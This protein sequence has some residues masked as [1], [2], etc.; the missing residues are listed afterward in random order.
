MG[1]ASI[2]IDY[3]N[4]Y[5]P[6][7]ALVLLVANLLGAYATRLQ[8]C[9]WLRWVLLILTAVMLQVWGLKIGLKL[10]R[11]GNPADLSSL[12]LSWYLPVVA[13]F[14]IAFLGVGVLAIARRGEKVASFD[15][16]LP[17]VNVVWAFVSAIYYLRARGNPTLGLAVVALAAVAV[18]FGIAWWAH[19]RRK[20]R[21]VGTNAYV[22][23]G[24]VLLAL[25]MPVLAGGLMPALPI[26]S[27][28]A[29]GLA[30][31]SEGWQRGGIRA[32][33]YLLQIGAGAAMV[34]MLVDGGPGGDF[35]P[36]SFAL[37]GLVLFGLLH[38]RWCRQQNTPVDSRLF[39]EMGCGGPHGSIGPVLCLDSRFLMVA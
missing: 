36:L 38:F 4:P 16:A 25:D 12:G 37:G 15:L 27:L 32:I 3:P 33:S 11:G 31:L 8:R 18:H 34:V 26:L 13:L 7:L 20:E 2:A 30:L 5:F 10:G 35:M 28:V 39:L 9:S 14:F 19:G 24:T 6:H 1:L 22:L 21:P 17:T 23:A 29:L